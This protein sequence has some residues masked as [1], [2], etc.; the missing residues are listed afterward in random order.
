MI[1]LGKVSEETKAVPTADIPEAI[2]GLEF[3]L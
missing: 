2:V 1:E 3:R